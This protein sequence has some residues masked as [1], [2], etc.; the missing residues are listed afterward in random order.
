MIADAVKSRGRSR[1]GHLA[2]AA[3]TVA[4][5]SGRQHTPTAC[6]GREVA[7]AHLLAAADR[8]AESRLA[9]NQI[10]AGHLG[11]GGTPR[12]GPCSPPC[13]PWRGCHVFGFAS[14]RTGFAAAP[15]LRPGTSSAVMTPS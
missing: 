2:G 10:G 8:E 11:G 9:R 1:H 12:V 3:M 5:A 14:L 4:V 7:I 13:S 15:N 6:S